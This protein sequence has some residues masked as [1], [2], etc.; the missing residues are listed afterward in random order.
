MNACLQPVA[1]RAVDQI[2]EREVVHLLDG[3]GPVGADAIRSMSDTISSG[4]FSSATAY[5]SSWL[6]AALSRLRARALVFPAEA[7]LAPDIGPAFAAAG[8]A[9]ALLKREPFA[10][11]VGGDRIKTPRRR[12]DR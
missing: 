8:L 9:R 11:R 10:L 5:C 2:V 1:H 6:N 12:T 3:V 7:A 4:G